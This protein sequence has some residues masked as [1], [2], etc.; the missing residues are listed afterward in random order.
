MGMLLLE[1]WWTKELTTQLRET[2]I[3][4]RTRE[5]K[6]PADLVT[7]RFSGMIMILQQTIWKPWH[8][9]SAIS[10]VGALGMY[11]T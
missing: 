3:F 5:F 2:F 10:T 1:L 9:T 6:E 8:T 11:D 7:I 4:S